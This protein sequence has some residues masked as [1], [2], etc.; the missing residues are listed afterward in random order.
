MNPNLIRDYN[1]CLLKL[2]KLNFLGEEFLD[3]KER[4]LT[5]LADSILVNKNCL[6][7]STN[8]LLEII[9]EKIMYEN[10]VS[11]KT[12]IK[13]YTDKYFLH[14]YYYLGEVYSKHNKR[15]WKVILIHNN[16]YCPLL[17]DNK[18]QVDSK[19]LFLIIRIY[20]DLNSENFTLFYKSLTQRGIVVEMFLDA[21]GNIETCY[22]IYNP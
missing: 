19:F 7:F 4:L 15:N 6:D 10:V 22:P 8:S 20:E 9:D 21:D 16:L 11:N 12:Y 17:F 13:E 18:N 14:L 5:E 3:E 1:E 2:S